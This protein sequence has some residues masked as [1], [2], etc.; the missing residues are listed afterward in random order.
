VNVTDFDINQCI[1]EQP[2]LVDFLF[3]VDVLWNYEM[4]N[5]WFWESSDWKLSWHNGVCVFTWTV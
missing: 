3:V 5:A 2:N 1:S 4:S